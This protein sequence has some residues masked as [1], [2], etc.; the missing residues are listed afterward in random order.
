MAPQG[1][2]PFVYVF[3]AILLVGALLYFGYGAVDRSGLTTQQAEARV[4]GKQFTP[5]STTYRTNVVGGRSY[6]Q[7]DKYPDAYVIT[8]EMDGAPTSAVVSQE[9]YESLQTGDNVHVEFKRTRLTGRILV[10]NVSR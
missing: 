2:N 8:L 5:G 6:V 3:P 7:S 1:V 4:T 9:L 10:T